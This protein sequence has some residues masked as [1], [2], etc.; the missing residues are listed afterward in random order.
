ML[1]KNTLLF[2][3][4]LLIV[5]AKIHIW[6]PKAL[7]NLYSNQDF[8]YSVMNFGT[9]PYGHSV[10]G[11]IFKANPYNA[12]SELKPLNWDKN[13]GTLIMLVTRGGCNFS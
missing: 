11:T 13:Y 5:L 1:L 7:K 2:L 10:Y 12:C 9:I 3:L 6:E 4:S 8:P